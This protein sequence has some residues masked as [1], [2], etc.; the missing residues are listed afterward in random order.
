MVWGFCAERLEGR[1]FVLR[2]GMMSAQVEVLKLR[3][4][5]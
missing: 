5:N 4:G 2:D 3:D 1:R